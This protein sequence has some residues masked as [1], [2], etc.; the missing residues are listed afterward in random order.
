MTRSVQNKQQISVSLNIDT[1]GNINPKLDA[2]AENLRYF[3]LLHG[4]TLTL[5]LDSGWSNSVFV[6]AVPLS[7]V[8]THILAASDAAI[9]PHYSAPP[10]GRPWAPRFAACVKRLKQHQHSLAISALQRSGPCIIAK[11]RDALVRYLRHHRIF[12]RIPSE[13]VLSSIFKL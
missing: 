7:T 10:R 6:P 12:Q 8:V 9:L 13:T 11:R 3:H 2:L 4:K 5:D 1:S